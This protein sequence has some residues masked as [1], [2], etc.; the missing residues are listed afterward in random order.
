[1]GFPIPSLE[2]SSRLGL[3]KGSDHWGVRESRY[4]LRRHRFTRPRRRCGFSRRKL[5]VSADSRYWGLGDE[6]DHWGG[7]D[8]R[9][10]CV[11]ERIKEG[12]GIREILP[13][14]KKLRSGR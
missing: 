2:I 13:R 8:R 14:K 3:G 11:K 4:R 7:H 1:M 10:N 12:G 9:K 6:S 5:E